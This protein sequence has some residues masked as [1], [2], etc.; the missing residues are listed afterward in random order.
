[1]SQKL[2]AQAL[3]HY[4]E[5]A[6]QLDLLCA[7]IEAQMAYKNQPGLSIGIVYDQALIWAKGFGFANLADRTPATPKTVYRIASITK[8]FTSTAIMQLR[9]AGQLQLDD[10]ITKHLP[11]FA[12]QNQ[13]PNTPPVTI[14]HLLTH[15]SGLPREAAFPYWID[16]AFPT[17]AE[18][19]ER[20]PN[21][22]QAL[23]TETKWKYS[24]LGLALLGE[25]VTAVSG[26]AWAD[27]VQTQILQ[28]L[29]MENTFTAVDPNHPLLATGY[30]RRLPDHSRA[31]SPYTDTR[32]IA[33]AANMATNI[34]DLARFAML[35]F[36]DGPQQGPQILQGSSLREMQR[37]HWLSKDWQSGRGLGFAVRRFEGK[38]ISSHG[39]ALQGY[40]TQFHVC[41]EDKIAV[42][43]LTNADDGAPVAYV[44]KAFQWVAPALRKV[45][46]PAPKPASATEQWQRY[47]GKYRSVWGDEQVLILNNELL[48]IDPTLADP[49]AECAK[50]I[51]VAEHTFRVET[52]DN[53]GSDGELAIFELDEAGKV[54][55][56]LVG[57]TPIF[58]VEGW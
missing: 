46:A 26:I 40:R 33:A 55:Q 44:E 30:G 43:V 47:T 27:Y 38:T 15:T 56:L 42:L 22:T 8:L 5:V 52:E 20:L 36:R 17:M 2:T 45:T 49:I 10:P 24:N 13:F 39:G 19:Q 9:D 21:Q 18:I 53:F 31:I 50:L 12:I 37:V 51:P 4:P 1:M 23:P 7:W 14:R 41:P 6:T 35:Q 32:G 34:E 57:N 25:I 48:L 28:P 11:W 29:D 54:T 3:A 58:P 16:N